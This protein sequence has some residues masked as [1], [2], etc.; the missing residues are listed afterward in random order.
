[1]KIAITGTT[2]GIGKALKDVLSFHHEIV[3]IDRSE[4]DLSTVENLSKIDLSGVDVLINNAGHANGGG[5]NFKNHKA[6]QWIDILDTNLKAPMFLTQTF[7]N[8]NQSGKIIFITSQVVEMAMGGDVAYSA[9]KAGISFFAQCLRKEVSPDFNIV[10]IRAK[11]IKTDFPKNRKIHS[12]AVLASFYDTRTHITVDQVVDV[13]K[14]VLDTN[15]IE[16]VNIGVE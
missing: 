1:M 16:I 7:I 5:R 6:E 3:C 10:E 4:F 2:S 15:I 13:I 11:R 12:N 8:Q 14:T 9:S